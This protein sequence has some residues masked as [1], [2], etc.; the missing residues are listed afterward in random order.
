MLNAEHVQ[1]DKVGMRTHLAI[2]LGH[3]VNNACLQLPAY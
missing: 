3:A 2:L 1:G